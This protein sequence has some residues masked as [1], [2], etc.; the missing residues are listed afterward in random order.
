MWRD[1]SNITRKVLAVILIVNGLYVVLITL[2]KPLLGKGILIDPNCLSIWLGF[3]LWKNAKYSKQLTFI[4]KFF[5]LGI[6]LLLYYI[7][8]GF[9]SPPLYF[10]FRLGIDLLP[11]INYSPQENVA[12]LKVFLGYD[13][14]QFVLSTITMIPI[15]NRE[16]RSGQ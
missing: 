15:N 11:G 12:I 13:I 16:D 8:I 6:A 1:L 3:Q 5:A 4:Y 9:P 2:L 10:K 7:G 14:F